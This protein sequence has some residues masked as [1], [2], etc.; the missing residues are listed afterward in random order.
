LPA[1][2]SPYKNFISDPARLASVRNALA[3]LPEADTDEA[4]K[5]VRHGLTGWL[6]LFESNIVDS[7]AARQHMRE[8]IQMEAELFAKRRDLVLQHINEAG[9][10]EASTLSGLATNMATNR[11]EAARKSSHDALMS[12]E[13]WVLANGFLDIVRK[14]NAFC[15]CPGLCQL[16]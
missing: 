7:D 10:L 12:L 3:Q 15:P 8:L 16:L 13:Q 5:A 14:R 2:K 9:E 11:N 6:A 4:T 1:P